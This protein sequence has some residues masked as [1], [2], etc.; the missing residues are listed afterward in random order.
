MLIA[1]MTAGDPAAAE[2]QFASEIDAWLLVV[3][4]AVPLVC[5]ATIVA[6]AL[7]GGEGIWVASLSLVIVA[8]IYGGLLF[9][10]YYRLE[11][12]ALLVRYGLVRQRIPYAAITSVRPTRNPLSS[13]ALSLRRLRV[14]YGRSFIMISP[15][16]RD[17]F[18]TALAA[19]TKLI[20]EGD[21]LRHSEK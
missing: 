20:R 13:P 11:T 8:G 7:N 1:E 4:A 16:R 19:R 15:E 2:E 3:L 14:D 12:A 21:T 6:A 9:P 10:L 18:L 17:E 5:L